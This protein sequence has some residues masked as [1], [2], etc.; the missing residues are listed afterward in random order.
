MDLEGDFRNVIVSL[1]SELVRRAIPEIEAS[2]GHDIVSS[3][4]CSNMFD[5]GLV[6]A[7]IPM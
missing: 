1:E 3:L 4:P 2:R 7:H 6:L 5:L